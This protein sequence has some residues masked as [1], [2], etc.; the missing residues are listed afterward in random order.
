MS[1][2]PASP[3]RSLST[4]DWLASGLFAILLMIGL[5]LFVQQ[6]LAEDA[7]NFSSRSDEPLGL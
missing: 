2:L 6:I 3:R 5:A 4:N 1:T 7:P